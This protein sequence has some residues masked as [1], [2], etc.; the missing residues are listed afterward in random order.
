MEEWR[1][2]GSSTH[3]SQVFIITHTT[4]KYG[5]GV[6][7]GMC[8]YL[9]PALLPGAFGP[10]NPL[11][12]VINLSPGV[13]L[14]STHTQDAW[15]HPDLII[16]G[17]AEPFAPQIDSFAFYFL[18]TKAD[19]VTLRGAPGGVMLASLLLPGA[20]RRRRHD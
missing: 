14:I 18:H 13:R 9:Q 8:K 12:H 11:K 10:A 7:S 2:S 6:I 3:K 17:F 20:A 4:F 15:H 1:A 19:E 5:C 16:K